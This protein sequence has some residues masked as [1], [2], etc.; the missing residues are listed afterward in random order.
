MRK[1]PIVEKTERL[2]SDQLL[3]LSLTLS[4]I[5]NFVLFY[6]G[7]C[8]KENK[9]RETIFI[10]VSLCFAIISGILFLNLF[11]RKRMTVKQV[12]LPATS[13][14]FFVISFAVWY[15]R[16]GLSGVFKNRIEIF[17]V[18]GIPAFFCGLY[19]AVEGKEASFFAAMESLSIL[20]LPGA[21]FYLNGA[22]FQCNPFNWGR[23]LGIISYMDFAYAIMP[24]LLV[25]I[26]NFCRN[27]D[28]RLLLH[29]VPLKRAQFLRVALIVIYWYA[30]LASGTRGAYVCV[31]FFCICLVLF[32]LINREKVRKPLGITAFIAGFLLVALIVGG[33]PGLQQASRMN[34]FLKGLAKG[35]IVTSE[36]DEIV[37]QSIDELVAVDGGKQVVNLDVAEDA[38]TESEIS[39][40]ND[41]QAIR[42]ESRG[43][44]MKL[45]FSEFLKSK[46]VGMYP[47]GFSVKYGEYPHSVVLELLCDT[48]LVGTA[49]MGLMLIVAFYGII[50][51]WK[52]SPARRDLFAL[53]LAYALQMNIS[54]SLWRCP[55]L[56]CALGYG[57]T[58][59][60]VNIK[61][62]RR[63]K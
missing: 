40:G 23:D 54:G 39:E 8:L 44:L 28:F 51:G 5:T 33:F 6:L 32:M 3:P 61:S 38:Q 48:G 10:A 36:E 17:I 30:I 60:V 1:Y 49:V 57:M 46:L 21:L 15:S 50:R 41:L 47:G 2:F 31:C 9:G 26:V 29:E 42:I 53:F 55:I 11:F 16:F 20:A 59:F 24:F 62:Y 58:L 52:Q 35:E 25:H 19:A 37:S 45:S 7:L 14:L 18:F 63:I 4:Y 22:I 13:V 56:L 34:F 43:T 12:L 27:S